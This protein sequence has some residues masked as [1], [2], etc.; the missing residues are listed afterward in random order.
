MSL[1]TSR[2]I[3]PLSE[4]LMHKL[5]SYTPAASAAGIGMLALASPAEAKI[6]YT[7]AH[8]RV[9]IGKL[10]DLDL[11]HDGINDFQLF[12]R[13]SSLS[14][15]AVAQTCSSWD[16]AAMFVYPQIKGNG[17]VGN[18]SASALKGRVTVGANDRFKTSD[19]FMGAVSNRNQHLTYAGP[20]ANSG[21]PLRNRYLGFKFTAKGKT[22]YGW[23]RLNVRVF[24]NPKS[25]VN[26]VLTG[27]AYETIPNKAIVTGKTKGPDVT[28]QSGSLGALAA[29]RK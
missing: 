17:I 5:N 27:Y 20:W 29:G 2:K 22:H 3:N 18:S 25:T 11:N 28:M 19:D 21:K 10:F 15:G 13:L 16:A 24:R 1:S 23:A 14:C 9:P 12:I 4:S 26:A 6:V 8:Q 7:P